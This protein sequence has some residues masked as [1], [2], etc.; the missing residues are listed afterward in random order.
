MK[1]GLV[2]GRYFDARDTDK[3]LSVIIVDDRL[4]KHF[5]PGQN[6]IGRRMYQP[7]NPAD[8]LK[9][10]EHT[11][12]LTVVGVVRN[13]R[14][15]DLAGS[16]TPVGAYYFPWAQQPSRNFT[17][18]IRSAAATAEMEATLRSAINRIDPEQAVFDLHTMT[19]RMA[20][21]VASRR[22]AM[23]LAVGFGAI[24]LMLS[25]IGI[26]GVLAYLVAQRRREIG[27]RMALGS[28]PGGVARFILAE[29]LKLS[30]G[31]LVV[32]L[33]GFAA[34][35]RIV[36]SQVYGIG[37]LDP[38]VIGCAAALLGIIAL[39]ACLLPARRAASVNPAI[40]LTE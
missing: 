34:L 20:L 18:A 14:V 30:A 35:K 25:A 8:L 23:M 24:A 17:F 1:I 27:I 2:S 38:L 29:G 6:P 31:G 26:Y 36:A 28:T 9:T 12:W 33:V 32:G 4:A 7:Q 37:A 5:W 11:Q 15:R 10:D 21:S 40:V 3:A 13:T 39:A 19:D 22:T 16:R